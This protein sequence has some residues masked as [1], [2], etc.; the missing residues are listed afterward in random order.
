MAWIASKDSV[1]PS[2]QK[3]TFALKAKQLDRI[4]LSAYIR[5]SCNYI[6]T[7]NGPPP[8]LNSS[9][10]TH[11]KPHSAPGRA[12]AITIYGFL[13][14]ALASTRPARPRVR[15]LTMPSKTKLEGAW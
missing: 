12:I 7:M 13:T 11:L 10:A 5:A 2:T 8:Q 9:R 1:L 4:S 6:A 15:R 14:Q 3:V